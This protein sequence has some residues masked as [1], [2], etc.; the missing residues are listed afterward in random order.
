MRSTTA[1]P[2]EKTEEM[3]FAHGVRA[4]WRVGICK[5]V[6]YAAVSIVHLNLFKFSQYA[7]QSC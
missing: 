6:C 3:V 5:A 1:S 2:C 4:G 7:G